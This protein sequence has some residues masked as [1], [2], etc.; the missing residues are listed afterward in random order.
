M[1]VLGSL[2]GDEGKGLT[3]SFLCDNTPNS[4]V[5]RFCGG[6]QAGHTVVYNEQRHVFSSF[7]SGTLQG[8]P[9]Y[10]SQHCPFYPIA[11]LNELFVLLDLKVE[12]EFYIHPL[13]PVITPYDVYY[14]QLRAKKTRHGSVGMGISTTIERHEKFYKLHVQ[15]LFY[16]K[17]WHEKFKQIEL[18][19]DKLFYNLNKPDLTKEIEQF[20][21]VIKEVTS[22]IHISEN[23]I[24]EKYNPIYE[25][26]QGILL[27]QDYGFFPHVTRANTT[28]K[29]AISLLPSTSNAE[30]YYV[31][32]TYQTRHGN[33][34]MSN[35]DKTVKLINNQNETNKSHE[36]QGE[37][38]TTELDPELLNY[39]FKCDGHYSKDINK[40]LV[41]TC[42]DQLE[43]DVDELLF[44]LNTKFNKIYLSY[45]DS[46]K[47]I[48]LYKS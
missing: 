32:R 15:D 17:I 4:I 19:Y 2:F 5:V 40:N 7:G 14:N 28:S 3:T 47:D 42:N 9:T 27:D 29:N 18:Y 41:I 12:P 26:A 46:Y 22:I 23:E 37:F 35:E 43:I 44:K 30:I 33:G 39:A 25:G 36:F 1:I 38:R 11:Y 48:K 45:G 13:C 8:V 16:E 10:W 21:A 20:R 34:Y 31:V 6:P 24:V